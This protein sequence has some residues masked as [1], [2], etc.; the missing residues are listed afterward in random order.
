MS[1]IKRGNC[2]ASI[3]RYHYN[4]NMAKCLEFEYT[5]CDGNLNNFETKKE[6]EM[7]CDVLIEMAKQASSEDTKVNK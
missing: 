3:K 1:P 2:D 4:L 5:G 7:A 6:C